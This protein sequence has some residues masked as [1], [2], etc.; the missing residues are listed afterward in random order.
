[1]TGK[2]FNST[3]WITTAKAAE[4][5]G[6]NYAHVRL[7]VRKGRIQSVKGGDMDSLRFF[8]GYTCLAEWLGLTK[9]SLCW[10]VLDAISWRA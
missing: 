3:E 6:Y 5:T 2:D 10:E 1:M 7:L 9:V 8:L 4:L